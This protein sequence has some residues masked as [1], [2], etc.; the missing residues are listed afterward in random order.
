MSEWNIERAAEVLLAA[1]RDGVARGPLTEEWPDL[2][3]RTAYAVQDEALRRR[4][5]RGERPVGV[6]LG[7]TA[8]AKQREMGVDRPVLA[9]LTDAMA[10]PSGTPLPRAGL[11]RPRAEPEIVFLMGR[12][13]AGPGVTAATA[14]AAVDAVYGGIEIL[15]SRYSSHSGSRPALPDTVADNASMGRFVL[16]PVAAPPAGLD[17]TL[18]GCLLELDGSVVDSATGAAKG[19]PAEGLAMAAN[20][21]AERGLALEPGW[22]VLTGG[23]TDTVQIEPGARVAAHFASLGSLTVS[24]G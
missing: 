16:G 1:E 19:H 9:W 7:L 5:A 17:L 11:I 3:L 22:L 24:G 21:L 8:K 15:D 18:Q 10:L 2:D 23:L 14:L 12:R 4:R 13:L 20:I 6:K